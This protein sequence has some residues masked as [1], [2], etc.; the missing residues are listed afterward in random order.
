MYSD[1]K[2]VFQFANP[3]ANKMFE[4]REDLENVYKSRCVNFIKYLEEEKKM[5]YLERQMKRQTSRSQIQHRSKSRKSKTQK[6]KMDPENEKTPKIIPQKAE[7]HSE[8]TR[9][10]S[11]GHIVKERRASD[12]I[13]KKLWSKN[14]INLKMNPKK[15][16]KDVV[17]KKQSVFAKTLS[18]FKNDLK[19]E[20]QKIK[21]HTKIDNKIDFSER[22]RNKKVSFKRGKRGKT[23]EKK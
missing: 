13:G 10:N 6:S 2:S 21:F 7:E 11:F 15:Y 3:K 22:K 16:Y 17:G 23:T 12:F 5:A 18:S 9:E 19:G 8:A 4:K 20:N 14:M 1:R